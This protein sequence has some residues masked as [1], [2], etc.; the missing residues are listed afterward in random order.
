[1]SSTKQWNPN[2]FVDRW[3][4]RDCG[5]KLKPLALSYAYGFRKNYMLH[6]VC[7]RSLVDLENKSCLR[8]SLVIILT[9]ASWI[10]CRDCLK[11]PFEWFVSSFTC[12][13]I[14]MYELGRNYFQVQIETRDERSRNQTSSRKIEEGSL[15]TN[16]LLIWIL[17]RNMFDLAPS[18]S[19]QF[20]P[21]WFYT[22]RL[23]CQHGKNS[24]EF[25]M[26]I[27]F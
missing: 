2:L 11:K 23:W 24:F 15:H 12:V 1:M 25:S 27:L 10:G 4:L 20:L 19:V 8:V 18:S 21:A 5:V 6:S 16:W 17:V 9:D 14:E 7:F 22:M 3:C 26:K 13:Q